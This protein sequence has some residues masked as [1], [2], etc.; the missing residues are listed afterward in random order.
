ML[1]DIRKISGKGRNKGQISL[2]KNSK[3]KF[4]R[5]ADVTQIG[6][7]SIW[8]QTILGVQN[9][10]RSLYDQIHKITKTLG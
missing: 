1:I 6:G 3:L 10:F 7:F 4:G 9:W 2:V 5:P 8:V